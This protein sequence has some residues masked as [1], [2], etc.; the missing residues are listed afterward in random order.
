MAGQ[1]IPV[2]II[3][4]PVQGLVL[5]QS[6]P[7][8]AE[9]K[10]GEAFKGKTPLFL[11]DIP[12]G[13]H[14]IGLTFQGFKERVVELNVQDRV[15][16]K[17]HVELLSDTASLKVSSNPEGATVRVNSVRRGVTPCEVGNCGEM[18]SPTLVACSLS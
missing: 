16:Q 9:V 6:T 10:V 5:I 12:L 7:P 2:D 4:E 3:L 8:G 14:R 11:S 15:P 18:M 17:V 1:K 13:T